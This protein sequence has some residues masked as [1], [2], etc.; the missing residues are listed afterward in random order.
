M[1]VLHPL[2]LCAI[3]G[4]G[5][6]CGMDGWAARSPRRGRACR[7]A[8][9]RRRVVRREEEAIV[10]CAAVLVG[11]VVRSVVKAGVLYAGYGGALLHDSMSSF[12]AEACRPVSCEGTAGGLV[13]FARAALRLGSVHRL[14]AIPA[15]V[16]PVYPRPPPPL[17]H[18]RPTPHVFTHLVAPS[19]P[20]VHRTLLPTYRALPSLRI[21]RPLLS[22]SIVSPI[23]HPPPPLAPVLVLIYVALAATRAPSLRLRGIGVLVGADVTPPRC[24]AADL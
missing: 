15:S 10:V 2:V 7:I 19:R 4:G 20:S 24:R 9:G 6:Y 8:H 12:G 5:F 14:T 23:Y 1:P 21:P 18:F 11:V 22:P 3:D 13:A 16:P 17:S